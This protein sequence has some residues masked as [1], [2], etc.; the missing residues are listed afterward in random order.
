[1]G[2]PKTDEDN[3]DAI[4][5]NLAPKEHY[6]IFY[7]SINMMKK[8]ER[9]QMKIIKMPQKDIVMRSMDCGMVFK[10]TVK[11]QEY[12]SAKGWAAPKRCKKCR[13]TRREIK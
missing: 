2:Y 12:F 6:L 11:D 8:Q 7:N 10:Y 4:E 13:K 9:K 1:M 3:R 5:E